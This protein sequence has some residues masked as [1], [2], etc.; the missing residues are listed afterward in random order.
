MKNA[1]I[2]PVSVATQVFKIRR[3]NTDAQWDYREDVGNPY[4]TGVPLLGAEHS[5]FFVTP[6]R[7]QYSVAE[8][9]L[10][11]K[12][13]GQ[14]FN[15]HIN[16]TGLD[17]DFYGLPVGMGVA[18]VAA[19]DRN[20]DNYRQYIRFETTCD[21]CI[22]FTTDHLFWN[23]YVIEFTGYGASLIGIDT[24]SLHSLPLDGPR[25]VMAA[26]GDSFSPSPADEDVWDAADNDVNQNFISHNPIF[27]TADQRI[28]ITLST[29]LP[30]LSQ[31]SV[32]NEVQSS[33]RD[34]CT[35]FFE[36]VVTSEILYADG[37]FDT[38]LHSKVYAGQVALI[39]K[40]DSHHQWNRLM[41]SYRLRYIRFYVYITYRV[42]D[43]TSETY[44][45]E[46]HKLEI[47]EHEFWNFTVKFVSDV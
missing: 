15:Q 11:L 40:Y 27:S 33:D 24:D 34:I 17:P 38:R 20:A 29:H 22:Q 37:T 16:E 19:V 2:H 41:T 31:V 32:D 5:T 39:R 46:K 6:D 21:G 7:P 18:P 26:T 23:Y 45:F 42:F 36:N 4:N 12:A 3:R 1:P 30:I 47:D 28:K 13:F 10:A 25:Y 8:F 35:A 14:V 43:T 9:I 44:K